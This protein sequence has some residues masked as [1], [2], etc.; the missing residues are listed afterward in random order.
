MHISEENGIANDAIVLQCL[1]SSVLWVDDSLA[2]FFSTAYK[3][4]MQL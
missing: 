2:R 4:L 1:V 3:L